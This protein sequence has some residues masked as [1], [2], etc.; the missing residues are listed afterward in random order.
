MDQATDKNSGSLNLV[1][2][3]QFKDLKVPVGIIAEGYEGMVVIG[4]QGLKKTFL[5]HVIYL[6][7]V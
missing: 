4:E 7:H 6:H 5:L 2:L 3:Q 1:D